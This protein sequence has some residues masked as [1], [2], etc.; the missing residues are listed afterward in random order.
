MSTPQATRPVTPVT[1]A[2][3]A[4]PVEVKA[5]PVEVKSV[6]GDTK[7]EITGDAKGDAET[8]KKTRK[9]VDTSV[10][11]LDDAESVTFA[12]TERVALLSNTERSDVQIK[13]DI[14]VKAAYDRWVEAGK[15]EMLKDAIKARCAERFFVTPENVEAFMALLD[16]AGRLHGVQIRKY[17]VQVHA[18]TGRTMLPWVARDRR[19]YVARAKTDPKTSGTEAKVSGSTKA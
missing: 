11:T 2:T 13:I 12:P 10:V 6:A 18:E 14:Q 19:V 9:R 7:P 1:P 5:A 4:A 15:P 3:K 17:P 8:E 16:N